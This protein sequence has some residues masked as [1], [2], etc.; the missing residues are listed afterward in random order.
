MQSTAGDN[1][2][3]DLSNDDSPDKPR[4]QTGSIMD[5][6][7]NYGE[8]KIQMQS[9]TGQAAAAASSAVI[10]LVNDAPPSEPASLN[11]HNPYKRKRPENV[12]VGKSQVAASN[13]SSRQASSER[14]RDRGLMTY[15]LLDL[16][17]QFRSNNILTI[18]GN[19]HQTVQSPT[20]RGNLNPRQLIH[21]TQQD[22]WTCGFRNL[23]MLIS[24]MP[25]KILNTIFPDGIPTL[26]ELQTSF[27]LL[28]AE[29]FDPNGANHHNSKMV[30]K[31]GK[32][33]WIGAVEVWSYLVFRGID[34]TIVQFANTMRNRSAV[35][36]FVW[37]YFS[38]LGPDCDCQSGGGGRG[39]Q[40]VSYQY[41]NELIQAAKQIQSCTEET[42]CLTSC[43]CTLCPLYL[44]WSGHSV[45]IV[46]IRRERIITSNSGT[47]SMRYHLIVFDPQKKG[48]ILRNKLTGE[49][50]KKLGHNRQQNC[51][52]FMEL[53]TEKL[54]SKDTQ[55]LLSTARA[56]TDQERERCKERVSCISVYL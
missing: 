32:S 44:Q 25:R 4:R 55:I 48:E 2:V 35:G 31:S 40:K 17:D 20:R 38:R 24:S 16:L 30:G 36:P 34:G 10:D 52:N 23:Q 21:Y 43:S 29:G 3:I 19:S 26:N 13:I 6:M 5:D 8:V 49:L 12:D 47:P 14:S 41:T 51:L 53:S 46:G 54:L 45:T 42:P 33:S 7:R 15:N 28:W 18:N 1:P 56:I 11:I 50:N 9:Q 27:E 39:S 37:A 22:K